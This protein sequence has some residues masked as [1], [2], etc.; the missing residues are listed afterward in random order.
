VTSCHSCWQTAQDAYMLLAFHSVFDLVSA[1]LCM[2]KAA[3]T[4]S[5]SAAGVD[6]NQEA[7]IL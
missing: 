7:D 3:G 4:A 6:Y 5:A 2:C 1:K